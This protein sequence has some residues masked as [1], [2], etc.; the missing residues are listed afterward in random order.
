MV[1]GTAV[2]VSLLWSEL[3]SEVLAEG[4]ILVAV[5]HAG[6]DVLG[7]VEGVS[8]PGD[9]HWSRVETSHMTDQNVGHAH[10]RST[11]GVDGAAG[12]F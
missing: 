3:Q 9:G 2:D 6:C 10:F 5:R 12:F 8:G 1:D 4:S 11:S 7:Q